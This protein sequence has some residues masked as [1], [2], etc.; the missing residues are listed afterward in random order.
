[1]G[2]LDAWALR[3]LPGADDV[4]VACI[5]GREG[6]LLPAGVGEVAF[7]F[8]VTAVQKGES[9]PDACFA[10]LRMRS[11]CVNS[12]FRAQWSGEIA[13]WICQSGRWPEVEQS[14][15]ILNGRR[16]RAGSLFG[17]TRFISKS[18]RTF[19]PSGKWEDDRATESSTIDV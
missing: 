6:Q 9:K 15:V 7:A 16:A 3:K 12:I 1:M 11:F 13:F 2:L 4:D 10:I 8:A 17:L 14:R 5:P 18:S 19:A